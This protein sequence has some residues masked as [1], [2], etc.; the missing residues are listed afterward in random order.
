MNL[1]SIIVAAKNEEKF[2]ANALS[3]LVN[4][5]YENIEIIVVDDRST[6]NTKKIVMSFRDA[7]IRLIEGSGTGLSACMNTGFKNANGSIIMICD[8]DDKYP[9]DRIEKQVQWLEQHPTYNAIC[10]AY[11]SM[12]V[13]ERVVAR[14]A[15][16]ASASDITEEL[17]D[18]VTR[19]SLCTYAMRTKSLKEIGGYREYFVTG[20]DIDFQLRFGEK[21][22]VWY[23]PEFV[24][25]YRI[26]CTSIT[27]TQPLIEKKFYEATARLFLR[28]RL[29]RG[30]DDL[31]RG[32]PPPVPKGLSENVTCAS[33]HIQGM[34]HG[35]AWKRHA[36]G[37][38][39]GAIALGV[40][41]L[42]Y[43]PKSLKAWRSFAAL[44][45]KRSGKSD[46]LLD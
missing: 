21:N 22:K 31:E 32:V 16:Y 8:A 34:L 11:Y 6:D 12:D 36:E 7:R 18:G 30:D 26:H 4:Q 27:H 13:K 41:F 38:K 14:L 17:Q 33:S 28:Q 37:N 29:L 20:S 40:R 25:Y 3:S 2:I 19:T 23:C 43:T 45:L 44:I 24:Y 39:I 42:L 9:E 15:L 35:E 1:V 46:N 10:G 5:Y